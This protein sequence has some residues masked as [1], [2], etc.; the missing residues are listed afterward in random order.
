MSGRALRSATVLAVLIAAAEPSAAQGLRDSDAT[1]DAPGL[2]DVLSG[3]TL[4]FFDGSLA[5]Y[6]A[7]EGYEYRYRPD[8]PPFVGAWRTTEQ[9]EVCVTFDNGF[10]RCDV[11]V[12]SGARLVLITGDGVRFPV[13]EVRPNS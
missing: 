5:R 12:R 8:G 11:I 7:D 9:S 13:R 6:A 10:S 3:Q 1:F 2:S 4:E